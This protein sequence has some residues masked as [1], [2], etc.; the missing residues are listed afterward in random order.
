[1]ADEKP[2]ASMELSL[3]PRRHAS[4]SRFQRDYAGCVP[5]LGAPARSLDHVRCVGF[6]AG[7]HL[8]HALALSAHTVP[9]HAL[10][11][12]SDNSC[13]LGLWSS[14]AVPACGFSNRL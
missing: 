7:L 12:G 3:R 5:A 2:L 1:M 6:L 8:D 4:D 10:R 11:T 14:H 13:S 9:P